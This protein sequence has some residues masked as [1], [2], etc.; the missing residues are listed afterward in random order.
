MLSWLRRSI[1][2]LLLAI[3]VLWGCCLLWW[4]VGPDP[5]QR[6]A[7]DW[8][9][10]N[11]WMWRLCRLLGLRIRCVGKVADSPVLLVANHISWHDIVVIQ[12][13]AP[14]GFIAKHEIRS[15]PIIGWMAY[16][17][18]TLFIRRGQRESFQQI[19]RDM[20]QRLSN[21]QSLVVFPEGCTSAGES[22]LPFRSRLYEPA[23]E[24]DVPIQAVAIHYHSAD[25]PLKGLAFVDN[26]SFLRHAI[27]VLGAKTIDVTVHFCE[28][29]VAAQR[30]R[31]ELA[32]I[33]HDKV[34]AAYTESISRH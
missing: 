1:R 23:I 9:V 27:R 11:G 24:V 28:P 29:V 8:R 3:H 16:R 20:M 19:K 6:S 30:Q 14:T 10:I 32:G 17:G 4:V 31:R 26:E 33:T 34:T 22:V 12:S 2:L 13:L 5:E 25:M 21:Q 15:W 7:Q 18:N